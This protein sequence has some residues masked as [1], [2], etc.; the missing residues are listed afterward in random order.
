MFELG[1]LVEGYIQES[2]ALSLQLLYK[3]KINSKVKV[4]FKKAQI[5]HPKKSVM[6]DFSK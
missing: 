3:P 5:S 4:Y 2:S 1:N 6:L